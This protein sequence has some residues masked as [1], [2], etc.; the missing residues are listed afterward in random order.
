MTDWTYGDGV[1]P[2]IL[3]GLSAVACW[4]SWIGGLRS[5]IDEA[6]K[7]QRLPAGGER[8]KMDWVVLLGLMKEQ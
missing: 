8:R 4:S 3:R 5:A 6:R 1:L 2:W 7:D